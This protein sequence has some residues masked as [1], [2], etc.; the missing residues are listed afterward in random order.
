MSGQLHAASWPTQ[1]LSGESMMKLH[2]TRTNTPPNI[3]SG[4]KAKFTVGL[5]EV[6][7]PIDDLKSSVAFYT[8]V[9]GL[10]LELESADGAFLWSGSAHQSQRVIMA[11]RQRLAQGNAAGDVG[12]NV[13]W[14]H[15]H[16]ALQ[17]SRKKVEKAVEHV[18]R[19]GVE[20][21][22]PVRFDAMNAISFFFRDPN[23]HLVEFWSPDP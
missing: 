2:V 14:H 13:E 6:F 20:V 17:V 21:S 10:V 4:S 12:K 19:C 1:L 5:S 22:G 18:R 23:G 3:A 8:E 15:V 7:L 16:F 11:T 9:V